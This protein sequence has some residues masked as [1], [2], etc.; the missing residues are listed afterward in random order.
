MLGGTVRHEQTMTKVQVS[1]LL[2]RAIK[3][4]PNESKIVGMNSLEHQVQGRPTGPVKSRD[5]IG[6]FWS[7]ETYR[8]TGFDRSCRP[9][10]DLVFQRVHPD[11]L[12]R[13][14]QTLY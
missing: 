13:V 11:D 6:L 14:R 12:A 10:L 9:A 1:S 3:R 7:E 2:R 4:L 5:S 8:I